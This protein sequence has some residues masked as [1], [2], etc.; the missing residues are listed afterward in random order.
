[1]GSVTPSISFR[2]PSLGTQP[3]KNSWHF[4]GASHTPPHRHVNHG[5]PRR[6]PCQRPDDGHQES[7]WQEVVNHKFL[8]TP[9]A[10]APV[11][12]GAWDANEKQKGENGKQMGDK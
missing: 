2:R 9:P 4:T 6:R 7:E 8:Q 1:M 5:L 10:G 11:G 3:A 12:H